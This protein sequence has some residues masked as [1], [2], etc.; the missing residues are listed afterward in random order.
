[1]S[2]V[3]HIRLDDDVHALL[4]ER[5]A[6]EQR[7]MGGLAKL[8]LTEALVPTKPLTEQL[9]DRTLARRPFRP[10]PK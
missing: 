9:M 7:T 5:A 6:L 10:D 3:V 8:L 4:A 2:T 1:M